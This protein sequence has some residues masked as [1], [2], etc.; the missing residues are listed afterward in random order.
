MKLKLLGFAVAATALLSG[1]DTPLEVDPTASLPSG[2]ALSTSAQIAAAVNGTY[3]SLQSD[4]LYSR[5][6]TAYPD[7]YADNL[8]F[9]GTFATD[10]QVG[11]RNVTATN[12]ATGGAWLSAYNGINRVNHILAAIPNAT[13]ITEDDADLYRGEALFVRALH[14]HT[15]VRWFGAV[16]LKLDPT[17][18]T[19]IP[20][21]EQQIPRAPAAQ[22]WAR[23]E[24]DLT[25]A[26][27]LLAGVGRVKANGRATVGAADA[28]LARV[29]LDQ[30]K[31]AQARDAATAVIASGRYSLNT[32]Y[33]DAWE[34]KN[35]PESI[36]ELQY[37]IDDSNSLAFWYF[38]SSLG[39]RRG[40]APT[41]SLFNAYGAGD[42]RRAAN[43]AGAAGA[44][45]GIKYFRIASSDDNVVVLRLAEMY[46]VRAEANARLGAPVETV[47]ADINIVRTRSGAPARTE[48]TLLTPPQTPLLPIPNTLEERLVETVLF[49][50]R[51]EFPMEGHR[52]FDLRRTG[53]AR[54]VLGTINAQGQVTALFAEERL[55]FPVPQSE[56][57]VNPSLTQ[58]PGY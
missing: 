29:Y 33:R 18:S 3:S 9:T 52:F 21:A 32:R 37:T 4:N 13:D 44:R 38:P 24:Q 28:L 1:C 36:F 47:L 26:R 16:P 51:L 39:G 34:I 48:A 45:Y 10:Q 5:N 30:G 57:D 42:T 27:A 41:N 17:P 46:L 19:G 23:I 35:S 50:R 58:N 54:I 6:L 2:E 12:S 15:L 22:V 31:W 56:I 7:L 8:S 11:L 40:F 53:R 20:G 25:E 14:Y 55:L 49:E 43:I